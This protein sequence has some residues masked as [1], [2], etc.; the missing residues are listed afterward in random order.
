MPIML[1][2]LGQPALL[3]EHEPP[4][5]VGGGVV[6]LDAQGLLVMLSCLGQL[7]LLGEGP[8]PV[9]VGVGV[10]GRDLQGALIVVD[11]VGQLALVGVGIVRLNVEGLPVVL[12]RFSWLPL[13]SESLA[14]VILGNRRVRVDSEGMSPK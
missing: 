12:D 6:R 8:T 9:G 7:P 14:E 3:S 1:D 10:T 13:L 5:G 4:V 11:G 2:R